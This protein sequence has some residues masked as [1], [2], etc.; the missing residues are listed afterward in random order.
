MSMMQRRQV[1]APAAPAARSRIA[2]ETTEAELR[3]IAN[4]A[5][6]GDSNQL[7]NGKMFAGHFDLIQRSAPTI[8]WRLSRECMRAFRRR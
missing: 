5:I 4:A 2:Y 1:Q 8:W 6:M 3:F 7:V